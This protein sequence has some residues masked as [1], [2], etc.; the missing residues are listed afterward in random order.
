MHESVAREIG[1][2]LNSSQR[3][4]VITHVRPDGDA[5]GSLLGLGLALKSVGKQVQM[6]SPDGIPDSFRHLAGH[7]HV[8]RRPREVFDVLIMVDCSDRSRVGQAIE[9]ILTPDVNIDHHV[10]NQNFA[11][12]NL[13]DVEAVATAEIL[14]RNMPAWDLPIEGPVSASLLTGLITD[15]LGFRTTNMSPKVLRL[16]ADLMERGANLPELY[17]HSLSNHSFEA[18]RYWGTGLSQLQRNGAM[19]WATLTLAD[20]AHANYPGRDDADLINVLTTIEDALVALIFVEQPGE[21]VKVSWRAEPGYD[22][23]K[24]AM[25]FGGGGHPQAA[26]AEIVGNLEEVRSKVLNVTYD[27]LFNSA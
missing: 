3:P 17:A 20:R 1:R 10:T 13:V 23:S 8:L 12:L 19:V 27:L 16:A 15:T 4:L 5:I 7:D 22:V 24:V 14:A 11:S 21:V 25:L 6:I 2:T 9:E 26:G 18:L